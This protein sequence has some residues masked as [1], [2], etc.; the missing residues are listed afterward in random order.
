MSKKKYKLSF[1]P[2]FEDDLNE[3]TDYITNHLQN[4]N[5]ALRLINDIEI[6]IN[7]RLKTPLAFTPY[8][9]AKN[10][11]YPYYR[12]NVKNFSIFYVLINDTME[13]RRILYSKR[14]F[15]NLLK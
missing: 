1:L 3:I 8:Q 2:L 15:D 4:P 11:P 13:V 12:I 10:R 6:A 7:K 9:S 14:N 5:A